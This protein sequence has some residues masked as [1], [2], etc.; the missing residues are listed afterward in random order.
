[1]G[2]EWKKTAD[3][4]ILTTPVRIPAWLDYSPDFVPAAAPTPKPNEPLPPAWSAPAPNWKELNYFLPKGYSWKAYKAD[5]YDS[6][7]ADVYALVPDG[8]DL[9]RDDNG[10]LEPPDKDGHYVPVRSLDSG[11]HVVWGTTTKGNSTITAPDGALADDEGNPIA[12]YGIP[13]GT[14]IK[15]MD[16]DPT[17]GATT[18]TVS[19][20]A[21]ESGRPGMIVGD[22]N[23]V[24][25]SDEVV[26]DVW[27]VPSDY[28]YVELRNNR[29]FKDP[30]ALLVTDDTAEHQCH[31]QPD[32]NDHTTNVVCGYFK[33]G[34]LLQIM[35]RLANMACYSKDPTKVESDCPQ[36][37][38][39]IGPEAASWA[40]T[41]ASYDSA[42]GTE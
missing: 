16:T 34:N 33:I 20:K 11:P 37:I 35:Q 5:K 31:S 30:E 2:Y 22:P 6:D 39:G 41:K 27:P 21:N 12:G 42:G 36:S 19:A 24:S 9:K 18:V 14:T 23:Q 15:D 10:I 13:P 38:F 7:S 8:Y 29:G 3:N 40:D 1:A 25:Y 4:F 32:Y 28:I 26:R 17:T